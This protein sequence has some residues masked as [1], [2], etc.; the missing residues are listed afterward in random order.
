[1]KEIRLFLSFHL[2]HPLPKY[3]VL[4][5]GQGSDSKNKFLAESCL[6]YWSGTEGDLIADSIIEIG[7]PAGA[8]YK[9]N[10]PAEQCTKFFYS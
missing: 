5:H 4:W 1:M 9:K 6:S 3:R 10:R 8:L 7:R 2:P